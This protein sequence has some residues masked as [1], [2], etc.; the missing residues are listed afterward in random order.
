VPKVMC[1]HAR[2]GRVFSTA[3][4]AGYR[5][6]SEVWEVRAAAAPVLDRPAATSG[7]RTA[8]WGTGGWGAAIL[9]LW[10]L[11]GTP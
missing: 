7:R 2:P 5:P 8:L 6:E 11:S 9:L 1:I 10:K 4:A 3:R